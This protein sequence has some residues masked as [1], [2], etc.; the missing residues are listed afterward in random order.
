MLYYFMIILCS[1]NWSGG[2]M[3]GDLVDG[4]LSDEPIAFIFTGTDRKN[5][6]ASRLV[7]YS[8]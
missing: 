7:E 5:H 2:V 6:M 3:K 4:K 8:A 1:K